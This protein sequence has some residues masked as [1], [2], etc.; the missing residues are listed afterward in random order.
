MIYP[1]LR[2]RER[3]RY[4]IRYKA[5]GIDQEGE[6]AMR[7]QKRPINDNTNK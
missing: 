2:K 7:Y 6:N 1:L 5:Y 3:E 4:A